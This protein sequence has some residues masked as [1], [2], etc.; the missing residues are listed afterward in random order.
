MNIQ[1]LLQ[2]KVA[3]ITLG[4]DKNRVDAENMLYFLKDFGFTFTENVLEAEIVIVNTCA[5]IKTSREESILTILDIKK[6]SKNRH[7]KTNNL[8]IYFV[9][10]QS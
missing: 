3:L 2:K 7:L 5:F 4:C 6:T 9:S 10:S 1:E 8:M